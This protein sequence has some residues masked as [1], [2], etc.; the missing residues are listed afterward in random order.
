MSS[1]TTKCGEITFKVAFLFLCSY[2]QNTYYKFLQE[3]LFL[4]KT[5]TNFVPTKKK[6]H[7]RTDTTTCSFCNKTLL[8]FYH[9]KIII[10]NLIKIGSF[11]KVYYCEKLAKS[12]SAQHYKCSLYNKSFYIFASWIFLSTKIKR[13][14]NCKTN[15]L[16]L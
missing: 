11:S 3:W 15:N 12:L 7:N 14:V 6:L 1:P 5:L 16:K 2:S 13:T 4:V 10:Q 9:Q 8:H